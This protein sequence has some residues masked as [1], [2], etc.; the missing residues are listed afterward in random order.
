MSI[1]SYINCKKIADFF[2][3]SAIFIRFLLFYFAVMRFVAHL[4]KKIQFIASFSGLNELR[5]IF[6]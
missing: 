6:V 2:I 5:K 3:K 4:T 1:Y